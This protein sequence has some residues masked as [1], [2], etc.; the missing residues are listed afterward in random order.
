MRN[1]KWLIPVGLVVLAVVL[2]VGGFAWSF[3]TGVAV[4]DQDPT[5]AMREYA[6]FHMAI[7]NAFLFAGAF[8]FVVA[9]VTVPLLLVLTRIGR[10][11]C[12]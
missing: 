10:R 3:V 6:Q 2:V 12:T 1:K 9:L 11:S 4:P 5:P 7:V 8:A